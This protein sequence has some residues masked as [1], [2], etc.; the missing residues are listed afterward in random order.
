MYKELNKLPGSNGLNW[1]D[2]HRR[3]CYLCFEAIDN[4][5]DKYKEGEI[6][7]YLDKGNKFANQIREKLNG[8]NEVDGIKLFRR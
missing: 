8:S 5:K 2:I 4:A 3:F 7:E 6:N 1:P